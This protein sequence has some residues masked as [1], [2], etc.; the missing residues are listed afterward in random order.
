MSKR[1]LYASL[2]NKQFFYVP[3]EIECPKGDFIVRSLSG[4]ELASDPVVLDVYEVSQEEA[5]AITKE[6]ILALGQKL[7]TF[8]S[9]AGTLLQA[10]P[11]PDSRREER[12]AAALKLSQ[13]QLHQDPKAVAEAVKNLFT[14]VMAAAKATVNTPEVAKE[15]LKDV[16]EALKVEGL[17]PEHAE[18]IEQLPEQLRAILGSE[19]TLKRLEEATH[20]LQSAAAELEKATQRLGKSSKE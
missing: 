11:K 15:Q 12:V 1:T 14:G 3:D 19:D 5:Q 7:R 20:Q 9:T 2:D 17:S 6:V 10:P 4:K 13:E 8:A 16:A 18:K